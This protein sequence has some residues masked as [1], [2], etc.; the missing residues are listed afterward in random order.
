MTQNN[1]ATIIWMFNNIVNIDNSYDLQRNHYIQD[2][3]QSHLLMCTSFKITR[4]LGGRFYG[5]SSF[6]HEDTDLQSD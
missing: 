6:F 4:T 5:Y 1:F 3:A 2:I